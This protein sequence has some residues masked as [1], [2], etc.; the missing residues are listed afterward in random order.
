MSQDPAATDDLLA[1]VSAAQPEAITHRLRELEWLAADEPVREVAPA[2]EGNMNLVLRVVTD[3][4]RLVVKHSRPYVEK[5]PQVAAPVER[6]AQEWWFYDT[7]RPLR[8][9]RERMPELLGYDRETRLLALEDLGESADLT[10]V[11]RGETLTEAELD[12][13]ATYAANLHT[14]ARIG[15]DE[16]TPLPNRAM[17]RLNHEHIFQVPWQPGAV[18]S[19]GIDLDRFEPGLTEATERLQQDDVLQRRVEALGRRYLADGPTLLHG[20]VFPGSFLRTD[21]G[22]Y[23]ID[24]EFAFYGDAAFDVG[25]WLAHLRMADQLREA[26]PRFLDKYRARAGETAIDPATV[27]GFAACEIIRRLIGVAQ[28]PIPAT[29]DGWRAARLNTAAQALRTP[30]LGAI[31]E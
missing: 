25:V 24:P 7:V 29:T 22:L 12:A 20:D 1:G 18:A 3:R 28:L 30:D 23:A 13:V 8:A 9:V 14:G 16:P 26:A 19:M 21:R 5:Y 11:Y 6:I 4:R 17:R 31:L 2:G 27:A 15:E 10:G